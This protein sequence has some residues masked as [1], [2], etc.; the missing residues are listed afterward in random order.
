MTFNLRSRVVVEFIGTAFLLMAVVGSGIMAER[1]SGGNV[2]LAL[3]ANTVA[4]GAALVAIILA[5]GPI[6]GAHLNPVVSL[7][8]A[9]EH[10]LS[11]SEAGAYALAQLSGGIAGTLVAHAMFALP[12][13]SLSRHVRHGPAQM[14]SEFV[15]TFGLVCVIWG[16]ARS[17]PTAAPFAVGG[18]ITAAYWFTASTSFANPAVTVARSLSDTFA[19]I[20]PSDAPY[21]ILAQI[22]GAIAA[23][24][25]FRWLVPGLPAVAKNVVA[26]ETERV[27]GGA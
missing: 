6:S 7:A 14:L 23:T 8:D 4:T 10:G 24:V 21:F 13:V 26:R 18:Y 9:I 5:F 15:A 22:A 1:L 11:W 12:L 19:G 25:V 27:G 16:C 17:R 3:L 2:A 20:R